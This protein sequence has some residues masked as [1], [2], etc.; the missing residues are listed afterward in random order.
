MKAVCKQNKQ[1]TDPFHYIAFP[2]C[3]KT[4]NKTNKQTNKKKKAVAN[5][6][7]GRVENAFGILKSSNSS[8]V[9]VFENALTHYY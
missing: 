7:A 5:M 1:T 9:P 3:L 8:T 6:A 4:K 2:T